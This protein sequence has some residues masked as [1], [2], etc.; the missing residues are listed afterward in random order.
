MPSAKLCDRSE[1]YLRSKSGS[2]GELNHRRTK[3]SIAFGVISGL[4]SKFDET[5]QTHESKALSATCCR[6]SA[7]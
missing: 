6:R 7:C 1:L 4:L 5:S 3:Y 2:I